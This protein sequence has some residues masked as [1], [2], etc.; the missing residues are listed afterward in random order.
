MESELIQ[1][2]AVGAIVLAAA[3]NL[4]LRWWRAV[5]SARGKS[6]AGCGGGCGCSAKE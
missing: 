4:G 6:D 3:G 5:A 1:S 2:A